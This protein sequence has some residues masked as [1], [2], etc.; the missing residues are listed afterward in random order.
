MKRVARNPAWAPARYQRGAA[1][2]L[3]MLVVTLVATLAAA[4]LWQQ[5]RAAEVEQAERQR[6]QAGWILTGALDWARLIL[7]EDARDNQSSGNADHLGEP[8]ATPLEEARL[9]SFLAADKNNNADDIRE[10]FLSGEVVDMQSRMNFLNV[11]RTVGSGAQAKV[12]LSEADMRSFTK[13]YELLGLPTS[14]LNAAANE[15][16]TTMSLALTDPLPSRTALVPKKFSQLGWL[17]IGR[18]SLAALEMHVAVLPTRTT[19]NINT[20]SAQ[21]LAA[22]I[23]GLDLAQARQVVATRARQPFKSLADVTAALPEL[24]AQLSDLYHG[25]RSNHFEVRGRLRLDNTIIEERSLVVRNNLDV[26]VYSRE[27]FARP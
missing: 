3:A 19:I 23:P 11:V 21:V 8:W 13:L 5:W 12:E 14:E 9:S 6:M 7:R 22:S 1:L 18:A 15:L 27:R 20:A 4:A 25:V 16:R 2:L 10:A 26:R 24:P 17:G